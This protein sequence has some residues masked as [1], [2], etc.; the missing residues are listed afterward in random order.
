MDVWMFWLPNAAEHGQHY[1][2]GTDVLV[3]E[4]S[5]SMS[6]IVLWHCMLS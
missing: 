1:A 6:S 2:L 4:R 3:A 5:Q